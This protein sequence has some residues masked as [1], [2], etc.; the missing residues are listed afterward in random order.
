GD[1]TFTEAGTKDVIFKS[2]LGCDSTIAVTLNVNPT[3]TGTDVVTICDSELPYQY[4]NSTFTEAGTKEVVFQA[5]NGCDSTITVTL[6]VIES[7]T[8]TTNI[9][10]CDSYTWNGTT[11]TQ[12]GTYTAKFKNAAGCDSIAILVLNILKSGKQTINKTE[13]DQYVLNG[14]VFTQSGTYT[15]VVTNNNGCDLT[16]T[17]NLT[18]LSDDPVVLTSEATD[19]TV[20]CD[21][22]GNTETLNEWLATQGTTG[23]AE[24]GFGTISWNHNYEALTPG[25]CNTGSATV[26]FTASDDCGNTVSTTATF[27]II[28]SETPTFTAPADITIYSADDCQYDASVETTGDVTDET[29][30]CCTDFNAEFTDV[31]EQ[32][33][34]AGEWIITRTWTLVDG[35]ENEAEP[36]VQTITVMDNTLPTAVC[37]NITV[38]LDENG[39]ASIT[40][41][42]IDGGS[43]DNCGI[44]TL[45]ISQE[46]FVCENL[47]E[48]E[49]T[50]TVVDQCGNT[51]ICTAVVTVEQGSFDC[52]TNQLKANPD[53]LTLIYC[54][55]RNVSGDIDL[56]ANDEGFSAEDVSFNVLTDIPD[57]V[58]ITDGALDYINAA[59]T[60]A[61]ITLTYSV[62]HNVN[63]E[64]C[65]TAEVTIHVLLDS[66]CDGVPDNEDIDDDNDGIVDTDEE[67]NA[68]TANLD[69]DSD[70]IVDRLDIDSDNDGIV[71][72]IEWQ[73]TIAE[74]GD[75]NYVTPLGTDTNEDGW[76]DAYDSENGGNYYEAWDTD[77]DGTPDYLDEDSDG[78]DI[79]DYIEGWDAVPHDTI[80]D[81]D[82]TG[83]DTD[84]DGLDN[85]YDTYNTGI[86]W[87]NGK[88]AI[89]SNAPLQDMAG[90][91]I[92]GVRD[93][94]DTYSPP[95]I[96][97]KP[98][99]TTLFI[100]E[101][102][103]PNN[104]NKNDYFEILMNEDDTDNVLFGE[105][106]PDA[107]LYIYNR[108][109]NLIF[110]K[111]HFG[112]YQVWG[113]KVDTWWDGRSEHGWTVGGGKVPVATYV[114]VLILEGSTVEKGTVFVNY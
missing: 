79:D 7:T 70:G 61:V 77:G 71:D 45:L 44:D 31:I 97:P 22:E 16:I 99:A 75:Y 57:N 93:W 10:E 76:D 62:C 19:L 102:F 2:A 12:S 23:A 63:T 98:Q 85:A 34:C 48:N 83:I 64:N 1:S 81:T 113:N 73:S 92:N 114:Y 9:T 11:Y 35:C 33:S 20:E 52:G 21:G 69:S 72:N 30:V 95:P 15:R 91:T 59:A 38:Q 106:Y 105:T 68:L 90:D 111:E 28:D 4:G 46:T 82:Y 87:L 53:V 54:P 25:C 100:P 29:D 47:G 50:L 49:V 65:D 24:A 86:E 110:E 26:T 17:L 43:S 112:N 66:D 109:G 36:Q 32:G 58:S 13:C 101:G 67:A 40:A 80:A 37:K 89:G 51:S 94:R 18:I 78:D 108:W 88:N 84:G 104:D 5:I 3:Y 41:S 107:H 14:E 8:S 96:P 60:Q 39:T 74:G 56:F 55:G 42:D 6:N 27:T 103:S